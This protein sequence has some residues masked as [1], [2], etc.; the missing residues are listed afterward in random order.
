LKPAGKRARIHV[1]LG[2]SKIHREF[3]L[4][5]AQAEILRLAVDGV[6]R[7]KAHVDNIEF[8]PEDASRTELDFL[9]K[10]V[11]A[12]IDAGATTITCRTRWVTP[13]LPSMATCSS[14][15]SN[16]RGRPSSHLQRPLSR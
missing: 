11:E 8:S 1:F 5:K 15:S 3:K 13:R 10:I 4:G 6:R 7:A 14:M 9:V 2:T 16:T 12:A